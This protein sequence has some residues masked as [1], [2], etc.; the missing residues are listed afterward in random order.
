MR[1]RARLAAGQLL[2]GVG[3]LLDGD[4]PATGRI[5]GELVL[6][7][8]L[9]PI[10]ECR[11]RVD[12]TCE[13]PPSLAEVERV[14]TEPV[15]WARAF[16]LRVERGD[17]VGAELLTKAVR[18]EDP[19]LADELAG[20]IED[21][22]ESERS[23]LD[24]S[25]RLF[26]SAVA[27]HRLYGSLSEDEANRLHD[28]ANGLTA[29]PAR[30]DFDVLR[31]K[32]L[33]LESATEELRERYVQE[34]RQEVDR[35]AREHPIVARYAER[36]NKYL[37]NGRV[38]TCDELLSRLNSG[39]PIPEENT[40]P[41]HFG[42]FFPRYPQVLEGTRRPKDRRHPVIQELR[43]LY[44]A[45]EDTPART[46]PTPAHSELL[47]AEI[48]MQHKGADPGRSIAYE[49]L[50]QWHTLTQGPQSS[51]NRRSAINRILALLG[52]SGELDLEQSGA[53]AERRG[54]HDFIRMDLTGVAPPGEALLPDFG[55]RMSTDG[56]RLRL[57]LVWGQPSPL[58][59]TEWLRSDTP[60]DQTVLVLYFGLLT[61]QQRMDLAEIARTRSGPVTAVVDE[62][63]IAY[64]AAVARPEWSTTVRL[65]A[66]FRV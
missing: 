39:E 29:A 26:Q 34:Q 17:L 48:A 10:P 36:L 33:N 31:D 57:Q 16:D 6:V 40:G 56:A 22:V 30:R 4:S 3:R 35:Q 2:E 53:R 5:S 11:V 59:F 19:A 20:R 1:C 61:V 45:K 51:G 23:A 41:D 62:A 46:I 13:S 54:Q 37:D 8:S 7:R 18:S 25:V 49:G 32:L 28:K 60:E 15:D 58:E 27:R 44:R 47:S 64:L 63:V 14:L 38:T 52:V 65:T 55:S 42:S 21:R 66:P 50:R 24:A 12:G 9:L 43:D